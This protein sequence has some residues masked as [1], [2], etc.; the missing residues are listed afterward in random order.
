MEGDWWLEVEAFDANGNS[1]SLNQSQDRSFSDDWQSRQL[2]FRPD[3]TATSFVTETPQ[4]Q[5]MIDANDMVV[6]KGVAPADAIAKVAKK[7]QELLDEFFE[8]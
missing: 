2:R 1:L 4:R 5:T 3:A 6:L 7:E 8:N